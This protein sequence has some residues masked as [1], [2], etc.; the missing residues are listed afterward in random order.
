M[1]VSLP[2]FIPHDLNAQRDGRWFSVSFSMGVSIGV[3]DGTVADHAND[4]S[5]AVCLYPMHPDVRVGPI[6]GPVV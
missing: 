1:D 6:D 4:A 5:A 3:D 2:L